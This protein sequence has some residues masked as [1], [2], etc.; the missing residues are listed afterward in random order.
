MLLRS[1]GKRN[2]ENPVA[3]ATGLFIELDENLVSYTD[4]SSCLSKIHGSTANF[5]HQRMIMANN[6]QTN[7]PRMNDI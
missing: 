7:L 6:E 4:N 2:K 5:V 1:R 3:A